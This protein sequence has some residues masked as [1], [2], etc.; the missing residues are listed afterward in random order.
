MDNIYYYFK[1]LLEVE[2]FPAWELYLFFNLCLWVSVIIRLVRLDNELKEQGELWREIM[3]Y[4]EE[5][6]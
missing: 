3:T 4:W 5:R 2:H 1:T 6:Y